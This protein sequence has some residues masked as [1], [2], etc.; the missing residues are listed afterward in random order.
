M[1]L[2]TREDATNLN[3]KRF[4]NAIPCKRN[5]LSERFVVDSSCCQCRL[6]KI[7][8]KRKCP[9]FRA[10]ET[11]KEMDKRK[12]DKNYHK[13]RKETTLNCFIKNY[14]NPEIKKQLKEKNKKWRNSEN[15]K[16]WINNYVKNKLKNDNIFLCSSRARSRIKEI[17][18]K[19][20]FIKNG[21]TE[22]ML[23]CTF[24]EFKVH[25]EKQ[26]LPKMG[27]H[28]RSDWHIDHIIPLFNA[29][30][31]NEIIKLCHYSNLRPIWAKDN[32][33]KNKQNIYLI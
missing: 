12:N 16:K 4:F 29:K 2:I 17:F 11:Q 10:A 1:K 15:G 18:R 22:K 6:E 20:N 32:L 26:F 3:L 13:K 7:R 31:E 19:N 5:H 21:N 8:E 23:G 24:D 25:I 28:N 33:S 30:K 27:W 9:N 14:K